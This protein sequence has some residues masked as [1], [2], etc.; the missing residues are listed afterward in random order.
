VDGLIAGLRYGDGGVRGDAAEALGKIGDPR[1]VDSLI[2][3]L[4]DSYDLARRSAAEALGKI[5]DPRAVDS[6]IAALSNSDDGVRRN[7]AEALGKIGDSRAL[8][9]LICSQEINIYE[10]SVFSLARSLA[11]KFSRQRPKPPFI[12]IYPEL[13]KRG[14]HALYDD[15]S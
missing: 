1:A 6:L 15:E 14:P 5:G 3:T 4:S 13:V 12:P 7:A 10:Q 2:A 9:K 8:E 11:I